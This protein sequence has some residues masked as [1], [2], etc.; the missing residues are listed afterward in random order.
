MKDHKTFNFRIKIEIGREERRNLIYRDL[1]THPAIRHI[2]I[3]LVLGIVHF[4][5]LHLRKGARGAAD[6]GIEAKN[7]LGSMCCSGSLNLT[8]MTLAAFIVPWL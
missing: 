4:Y 6:K 3:W 7:I 1:F 2:S 5:C 8:I